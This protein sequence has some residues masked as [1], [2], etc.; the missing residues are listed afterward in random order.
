MD[1]PRYPISELHP[2]KFW[3]S[4]EF[5]SWK[6]NFKSEVC[7]NSVFPQITM[8]W[9]KEVEIAKSIDDLMTS[10]SFAR[11][12]DFPDFEMLDAKIASAL[13]KLLTSVH[14][15]RRVSVDKVY[16]IYSIYTYRMTTFKISTQDVTKL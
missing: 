5:Q 11:R 2:G 3:D 12:R 15:R 14:F 16:Q 10:Q 9:I 8:H 4:L 13:K 7:A 1:Y 6:V